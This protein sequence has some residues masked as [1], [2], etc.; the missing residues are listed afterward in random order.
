MSYRQLNA[1]RCDGTLA[2]EDEVYSLQALRY[3]RADLAGLV[4][5]RCID[6]LRDNPE[7]AAR[8]PVPFESTKPPV[9]A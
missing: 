4:G 7:S 1:V 5:T 8:R 6:F 9:G 3:V 2:A